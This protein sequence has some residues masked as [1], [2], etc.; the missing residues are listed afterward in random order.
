MATPKEI[1]N[2][3]LQIGAIALFLFAVFFV[4]FSF[5][6]KKETREF[7]LHY[8][9][10]S[11]KSFFD[12]AFASSSSSPKANSVLGL[13]VNHHLLAADLIANAVALAATDKIKTVVLLSP[14]HFGHGDRNILISRFDWQTPYG[15]LEHD[16]ALS[17][18][19]LKSGT[20]SS[21]ELPFEQEHGVSGVVAFI[22]KSLPN[23]RI[24]PIILKERT[25][26]EELQN[27]TAL[28]DEY[29]PEDALLVASLDFSHYLPDNISD[30]HD[31]KSEEV[32]THF[33]FEGLRS[34]DIDSVSA[35]YVFLGLMRGRGAEKAVLL[36]HSNSSRIAGTFGSFDNTSY[37]TF[38]Y[39]KGKPSGESAVTVLAVGDMMLDRNVRKKMTEEGY[40]YPWKTLN[41]FLKG[42][43]IVLAN[44]EGSFTDFPS[45]TI[46]F[47]NKTLQFTFD[48]GA[49]PV[50]ARLGFTHFSLAN[51]H[52]L[53]FGKEGLRQS[54]EYLS[55][56]G[57]AFF[58]DPLNEEN[59]SVEKVVRGKRI[60]F[61]GYHEF[62]GGVENV[63]NEIKKLKDRGNFVVVMPH[64]G[65]EYERDFSKGQQEKA[66]HFIDAGADLVLGAHPHVVQPIEL[67]KNRAIFYSLGNFVFDQDFS[68][69]TRHGLTVGITLRK[70]DVVFRIFPVSIR[71]AETKLVSGTEK[72]EMLVFLA[73]NSVVPESV[74][75]DILKGK[76]SV[77]NR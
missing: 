67:Y 49:V 40:G 6:F 12:R 33:D 8:S 51:N 55:K 71:D 46:D 42:S 18:K 60:A 58:G 10:F 34:L 37:L 39:E 56:A 20:A 27:F 62:S 5:Y 43:D 17:E 14:N 66:Y 73:K 72:N 64:W 57:L 50:L 32:F 45:K 21:D 61:V 16:E 41:R 38:A 23:A 25:S 31:E 13:V 22:K 70:D 28:L 44:L 35:S 69:A 15:I 59:L 76:F 3:V 47:K 68:Y 19:I 36:D 9:Y 53:N 74:R 65:I 77:E 24:V 52:T 1:K 4:F 54:K 2:I 30:F 7:P 63:Y 11:D 48:A 75:N 29:L 26:E